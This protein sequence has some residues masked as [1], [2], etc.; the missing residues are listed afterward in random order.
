MDEIAIVADLA[1][2]LSSAG[3]AAA[4]AVRVSSRALAALRVVEAEGVA[5]RAD[6][7]SGHV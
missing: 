4:Q 3:F 1:L 2:H 5:K 6:S 7:A